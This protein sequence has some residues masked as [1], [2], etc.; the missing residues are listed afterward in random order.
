MAQ[1]GSRQLARGNWL[2]AQILPPPGGSHECQTKYKHANIPAAPNLQLVDFLLTTLLHIISI[3]NQGGGLEGGGNF[4]KGF[5]KRIE[6]VSVGNL[7]FTDAYLGVDPGLL[8]RFA[9]RFLHPL[10]RLKA[11][12]KTARVIDVL[13]SD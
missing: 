7:G 13:G 12:K 2:L 11:E 9:F 1:I 3:K 4:Y 6:I 8:L 5:H 10:R